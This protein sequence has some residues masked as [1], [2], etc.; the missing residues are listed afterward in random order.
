MTTITQD[1]PLI[2]TDN[3]EFFAELLAKLDTEAGFAPELTL[4]HLEHFI[5]SSLDLYFAAARDLVFDYLYPS[6]TLPLVA[7]LRAHPERLGALYPKGA[8][9]HLVGAEAEEPPSRLRVHLSIT[10]DPLPLDRTILRQFWDVALDQITP[11][12]RTSSC[13]FC[14]ASLYAH[15]LICPKCDRDVSSMATVPMMV[16]H[17]DIY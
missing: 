4:E 9:I 12:A 10:S 14:G 3:P 7:R 13:E 15:N 6:F 11:V 1:L 2:E 5:A 8:T 17:V 16:T